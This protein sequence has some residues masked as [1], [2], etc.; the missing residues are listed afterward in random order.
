MPTFYHCLPIITLFVMFQACHRPEEIKISGKTM[1][2]TWS[3]RSAQATASMRQLIQSHLDQREAVLSH[4]QKDSA[5]SRFNESRS[6]DWQPVPHE[7]ISVVEL[8][9]DI[10][11][12]TDGALDI[13]LAPL[14]DLWGFGAS[15]PAKSIPTETQIAEAKTRCG[16]QHLL[17]RLDPPALKKTLPDLR[18]NVASVT[19]GFV[20]D[21]L[22]AL[23]K[24]HGLSD[25]L[26][27]VGGEVAAIGHAPD[28][29]PWR[30]G[31]QTP[32]ATTG[33]SLQTLPLSDLCIAT[34][35][36]YRHRFAKDAQSYSHL[37]DPR[38]GNPI[39]HPLTSVS[40][41]HT[42]SALADGYATA[43][44][45]LGPERGREIADKLG[46][47]VIWILQASETTPSR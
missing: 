12:E 4:W 17:T 39:V 40:V 22:I 3:L 34:S 8:A 18:I 21:E 31:I 5:I 26:L 23:L 27:E 16:W 45:L 13:T 41:I 20:I 46:L 19:E 36:N 14:I 11:L 7:L 24:Q 47:R 33:D 37:I 10:A 42:S 44:M 1:G 15:G 35:G 43:L 9:R 28:G 38:S 2:T 32:E 30:V 25:F 29:K 6:S